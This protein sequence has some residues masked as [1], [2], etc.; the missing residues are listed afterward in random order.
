M[1]ALEKEHFN[2]LF[3]LY[4]LKEEETEAWN[5]FNQKHSIEK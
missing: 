1:Q 5:I 3:E 4:Q 2:L